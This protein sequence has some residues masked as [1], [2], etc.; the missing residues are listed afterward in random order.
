MITFCAPNCSFCVSRCRHNA[1]CNSTIVT[2]A[3]PREAASHPNIPHPAKRS[4]QVASTITLCNQLNRSS[5]ARSNVGRR[6]SV[7]TF[8]QAM[9]RPRHWPPMMRSG[10][11]LAR[12]FTLG[13]HLNFGQL[14]ELDRLI[15]RCFYRVSTQCSQALLKGV[16]IIHGQVVARQQ[17][18]VMGDVGIAV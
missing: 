13:P 7:T 12:F 17:T 11:G 3:A 18:D 6:S 4:R 10:F 1:V 8:G 5:R 15:H 9:R 2:L 16:Q 14:F